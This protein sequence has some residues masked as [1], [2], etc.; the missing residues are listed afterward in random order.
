MQCYRCYSGFRLSNYSCIQCI[1]SNCLN[2]SSSEHFCLTCAIGFTSI[3]GS[4]RPCASNCLNCNELGEGTC[5][6]N[7][8]YNGYARISS[9]ECVLCAL[10]CYSCSSVDISTCISCPQGSFQVLGGQCE[11]CPP[12]CIEC[13]SSSVCQTCR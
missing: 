1:D 10:G 5:D 4:C 7:K 6:T 2:C 11:I 3:N 8:C 13:S 9:K 12:S